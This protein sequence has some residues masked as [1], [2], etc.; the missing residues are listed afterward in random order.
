MLLGSRFSRKHNP[1]LLFRILGRC[2][3]VTRYYGNKPSGWK[4]SDFAEGRHLYLG[5][6]QASP[7][8]QQTEHRSMSDL[9]TRYLRRYKPEVLLR[10]CGTNTRTAFR[11]TPI[12]RSSHHSFTR[13]LL[14]QPRIPPRPLLFLL[15]R[16]Q[17]KY[18]HK[19]RLLKEWPWRS[20]PL[21]N[22]RHMVRAL[23]P[24]LDLNRCMIRCKLLSR[25]IIPHRPGCRVILLQWR[26]RNLVHRPRLI[27]INS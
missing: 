13:P 17:V 22:R 12:D 5:R 3:Q 23:C 26:I 24:W 10:Q 15:P 7:H 4:M 14:R 6:L 8:H 21:L 27:L 11:R 9:E 20:T 16:L 1:T 18:R 2:R 25:H 19:C